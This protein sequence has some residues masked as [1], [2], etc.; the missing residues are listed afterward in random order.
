MVV[1]LPIGVGLWLLKEVA[2]KIVIFFIMFSMVII[3]PVGLINPFMA[4]D[5]KDPPDVTQLVIS[6]YPWVNLGLLFVP[7]LGI[8]K[9]NLNQ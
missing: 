3:V 1:I 2:R 5:V 6:I 8:H 7:I 9:K 4:M